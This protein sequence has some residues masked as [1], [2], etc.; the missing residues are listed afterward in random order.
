MEVEV[1][2]HRTQLFLVH[3]ILMDTAP[4]ADTPNCGFIVL[5]IP[6]RFL[7]RACTLKQCIIVS[8]DIIPMD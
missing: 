4:M 3:D 8:L 5:L 7:M 1:G 2:D 6:T